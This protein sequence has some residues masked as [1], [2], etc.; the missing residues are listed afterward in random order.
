MACRLDYAKPLSET[1]LEY[2]QLDSYRNKL[3]WNFN[4]NQYISIQENPF[5]NVVWRMAIILSRT[6]CVDGFWWGIHRWPMDF[7]QTTQIMV[8]QWRHHDI[9][10]TLSIIASRG[11]CRAHITLY[12]NASCT[13]FL[14]KARNKIPLF[15]IAPSALIVCG[16]LK[17]ILVECKVPPLL[18]AW[19]Y[20]EPGH[21]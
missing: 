4:Q 8:T 19:Q 10:C 7:S 6:Q 18:T 15:T 20:K 16:Q 14:Q 21:Q 17:Y 12:P 5:Q 13:K 3:M 11:I 9:G 1:M 2:Y